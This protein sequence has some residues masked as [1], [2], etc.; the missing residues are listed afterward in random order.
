[1]KYSIKL[2]LKQLRGGKRVQV[3]S[4]YQ[5]NG[6]LLL[7]DLPHLLNQYFS[8]NEQKRKEFQCNAN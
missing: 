6:S 1:M 7:G 2:R 3:P 8:K 4:T 5:I